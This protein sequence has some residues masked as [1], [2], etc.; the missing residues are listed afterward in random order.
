MATG[1]SVTATEVEKLKGKCHVIAVNDSYRLAPWADMLYAA[2]H[3]WWKHHSYCPTFAKERW[4]SV[5]GP[6]GWC[7]EATRYG[8]SLI[9]TRHAITLSFDPTVIHTGWNSAF[10]ALNIAYL[11]GATRILL[12]GVDLNNRHGSHWFGD[13]PPGLQRSSPYSTFKRAFT[14]AAPIMAETGVKV[15]NCSPTSALDCYPVMGVADA[16]RECLIT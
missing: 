11:R 7:Q 15:V 4:S 12:L 5:S 13:H 16:L 3:K 10:Q 9:K 1:P 8:L 6:G 14:E 2:D